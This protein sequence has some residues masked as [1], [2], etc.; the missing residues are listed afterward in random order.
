VADALTPAEQR[1]ADAL[2]MHRLP[3]RVIVLEQLATT[4]QMA[5]EALG[6]EVGRIVKSLMF[7]GATSGRP[8]LL[9]VSGANR[10]HEKRAGR[11]IGEA[12]ERS[13][14]DFVKEQTGFSIGGVSPYGHPAPIATWI[15]ED[16]F[17]YETVWAAAGNPRSVFEITARD[18]E[19]T[20]GGRVIKVT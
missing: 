5:A 9:L 16:L 2:A 10:V 1:V 13:D 20:T 3:G 17:Q 12:L 19:R 18:L 7:R 14:A 15:D 11:V 8:Y 6:I 4:A